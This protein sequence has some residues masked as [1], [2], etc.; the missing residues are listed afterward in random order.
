[1]NILTAEDKRSPAWL[2][3][4]KYCDEQLLSLRAELEGDATPDRTA[5]LRGRIKS[6]KSILS[7]GE[8]RATKEESEDE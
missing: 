3:V 7:L 2:K 4:A 8:V 5:T 1:M 6:L